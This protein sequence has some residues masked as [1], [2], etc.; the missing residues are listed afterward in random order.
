MRETR[1][2][3]L[4]PNAQEST[5]E[6]NPDTSMTEGTCKQFV[7]QYSNCMWRVVSHNT[8]IYACIFNVF[9]MTWHQFTLCSNHT[10]NHDR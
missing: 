9:E 10:L 1:K 5:A 3:E 7:Q 8:S 6:A 2:E 4:F